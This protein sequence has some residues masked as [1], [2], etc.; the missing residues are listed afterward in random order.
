MP[1]STS[2]SKSMATPISQVPRP[3]APRT[4]L[5]DAE[6]ATNARAQIAAGQC[7]DD[8]GLD[9]FLDSLQIPTTKA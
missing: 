2:A 3:T 5:S 4:M 1:R 7:L 8:E 9:A 6:R